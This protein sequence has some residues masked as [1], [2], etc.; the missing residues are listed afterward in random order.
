MKKLTKG[1]EIDIEN[2]LSK[3]PITHTADTLGRATRNPDAR[4]NYMNFI[5]GIFTQPQ[6]LK[7]LKLWLTVPTVQLTRLLRECCLL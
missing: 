2:Q 4:G 5:S 7:K 3:D 6:P 1:L